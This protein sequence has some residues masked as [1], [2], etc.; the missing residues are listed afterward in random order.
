MASITYNRISSLIHIKRVRR[1]YSLG[2]LEED[3]IPLSILLLK[4]D[5]GDDEWSAKSGSESLS[6]LFSTYASFEPLEK[7]SPESIYVPECE[8]SYTSCVYQ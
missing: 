8:M 4:K 7:S 3:Y 6:T 5:E 2:L 1:S